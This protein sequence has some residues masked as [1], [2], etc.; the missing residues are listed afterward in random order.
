DGTYVP[1]ALTRED[2]AFEVFVPRP[3]NPGL[4][5][6]E[7]TVVE[8]DGSRVA[9]RVRLGGGPD[10][11][12]DGSGGESAE[13]RAAPGEARSLALGR[14]RLDI[15]AGALGQQAS[16]SM[17][18]LSRGELP[19]LDTGMTNVTGPQAGFRLGPH[20]LRFKQAVHLT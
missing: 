5:E 9:R 17:R 15:P 8:A 7:L 18:A 3:S 4:W 11:D 12:G 14:A 20:G 2:G 1:G 13:T 6:V 10:D 16:L 19:A